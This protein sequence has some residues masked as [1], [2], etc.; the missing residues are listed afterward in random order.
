M[1]ES[2]RIRNRGER[3]E[4]GG[5]LAALLEHNPSRRS[6]LEWGFAADAEDEEEDAAIMAEHPQR[7][8]GGLHEGGAGGIMQ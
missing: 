8:G 5:Q 1:R 4:S 3:P 2:T 7:Q 6:Q